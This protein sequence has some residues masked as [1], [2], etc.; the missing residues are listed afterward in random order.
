MDEAAFSLQTGAVNER[1]AVSEELAPGRGR[2]NSISQFCAFVKHIK[3]TFDHNCVPVCK[4][5]QVLLGVISSRYAKIRHV[6]Q[7]REAAFR[8]KPP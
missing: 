8:L 4:Y 7:G 3:L 2:Y 1:D 6:L 5:S